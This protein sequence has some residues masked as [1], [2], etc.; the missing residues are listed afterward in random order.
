[1]LTESGI[2]RGV[3]SDVYH[4]RQ[5]G[6]A[7]KSAL[8]LV[9]RS[10]AH[11]KAWVDGAEEEPSDALTFGSA[12]H[13]ALLEPDTFA[14]R[15]AVEP[16][17]GDCRR[18]ENKAARDAWR[19]EHAGAEPLDATDARHIAGMVAAVRA[20]P[21]ASRMI[22][23][24]EAEVTLRWID[25]ATGLPCKSRVDYYVP[26]RR[27]VVDAKSTRDASP[28]AFRKSV[29]NFRYHVQDAFYREAF[30]ACG[31]PIEHFAF[32]AVEKLPPYAVAVYAL[33]PGAIARGQAAARTDLETLARCLQENTWPGYPAE[34]HTLD[35][36]PWAD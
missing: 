20:H 5:I 4:A 18:K 19:A 6:I 34:I 33:D 14:T 36:P 16:D 21:L 13:V 32:I 22:R 28:E 24:G 10:P 15:Y 26:G 1:M 29:A 2:I 23:G 31:A 30:R 35:L 7:S 17:F 12:F 8:D 9:H 3:P 11:Y 27:L 25:E